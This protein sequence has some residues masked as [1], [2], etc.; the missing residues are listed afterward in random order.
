MGVD[1]GGRPLLKEAFSSNE[2]ISSARKRNYYR[3]QKRRLLEQI[4]KLSAK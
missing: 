3:F 1:E 4:P 2:A